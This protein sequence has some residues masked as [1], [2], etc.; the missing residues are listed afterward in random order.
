MEN[1]QYRNHSVSFRAS[2][3]TKA[4]LQKEADKVGMSLSEYCSAT[5]DMKKNAISEINEPSKREKQLEEDNAK[6]QEKILEL[7]QQLNVKEELYGTELASNH[8][9][10]NK[11]VQWAYHYKKIVTERDALKKENEIMKNRIETG[12]F[13]IEKFADSS[14]SWSPISMFAANEIRDLK[15]K[16]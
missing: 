10:R 3:K 16:K 6:L 7:T 9:L 8:E 14:E 15:I 11:D 12:N 4:E 1:D 13:K 5:M 2:A